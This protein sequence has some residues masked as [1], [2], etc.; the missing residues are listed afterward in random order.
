VLEIRARSYRLKGDD[1][2]GLWTMDEIHRYQNCI[3]S[4]TGMQ[5]NL[6]KSFVAKDR[7]VFC[8]KSYFR[9][10]HTLSQ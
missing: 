1:L 2:I 6:D 5:V 7:G 10:G 4:L 3:E 8:E 9:R